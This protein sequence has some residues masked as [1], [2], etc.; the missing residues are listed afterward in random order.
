MFETVR[1]ITAVAAFAL[2]SGSVQAKP[3]LKTV[4]PKTG[5]LI[6]YRPGEYV[7]IV[8]TYAF[9]IDG[10]PR[11]HINAGR[12]MRFELPAGDHIVAHPLT[13]R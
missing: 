8:R 6:V 10:G 13:S 12:Y 3:Q 2:T 9:S 4:A 5:T 7:G 11:H 1:L